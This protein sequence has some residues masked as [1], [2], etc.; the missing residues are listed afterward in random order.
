MRR[1]SSAREAKEFLVSRAVEEAQREGA[2]LSEVERKMLYF[3]ETDW[4]LPDIAEVNDE[5]DRT[6]N[7]DDYEK[8]MARLFREA[9]KR[10]RK[11]S[12]EEYDAWRSAIRVLQRG[13]HY[14]LVMVRS[15]S[16]KPRW[17]TLKLIGVATIIVGLLV[18]LAFVSAAYNIDLNKHLS[19]GALIPYIWVACL[20]TLVLYWILRI[21]LGAQRTARLI[22][23]LLDK[24]FRIPGR[25][26]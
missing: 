12:P 13:D 18:C 10:D 16:Q 14:I 7:R 6:Y 26:E 20:L 11:A 9:A 15:A 1:F 21:T 19:Q 22:N 25:E 8:K 4:T 23:W 17:D 24:A 2:P 5:F 3:S